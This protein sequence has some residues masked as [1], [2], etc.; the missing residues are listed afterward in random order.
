VARRR[1]RRRRRRRGRRR[2]KESRFICN[3]RIMMK[4]KMPQHPDRTH[5][6]DKR[7]Y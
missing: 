5:T 4:M 3:T 1:R 7:N 2:K 6:P